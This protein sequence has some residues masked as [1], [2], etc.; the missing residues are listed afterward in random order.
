MA[1]RQAAATARKQLVALASQR[2]G[3]PAGELVVV[4]GTVKPRAGSG[5]VSYGQLVG[6]GNVSLKLDK[7]VTTKDP[8][9][10]TL[11]GTSVPRLDIPAKSTGRFT[12]MQDFKLDGML[13]G[14]VVRPPAIGAELQAVDEASVAQAPGLVKVVRQG[15]F[16]AVVARSEWGAIKAAAALRATWSNWQGLPEQARLWEHVWLCYRTSAQLC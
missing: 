6:G 7:D 4:D 1:I 14:R 9:K 12:Y 10:F 5:G 2:L 3:V 15:N 11:V 8:A 16:L 13:H